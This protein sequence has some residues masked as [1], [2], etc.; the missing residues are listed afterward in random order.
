MVLTVSLIRTG[1]QQKFEELC[2][3]D[4]RL[5]QVSLLPWDIETFGFPVATYR[6]GAEELDEALFEEAMIRFA[7][8]ARRNGVL[9]CSCV[10]PAKSNFWIGHLA[11]ARF[12]FVDFGLRPILSN[13]SHA[14]LPEARFALRL[15]EPEDWEAVEDIALQ[16]FHDG[17]YHADPFFPARL[18][19]LRYR[20]WMKR[21]L[22]DENGINRVY[23]LGPPATVQGFY[24]LTVEGTNSDLRL[25]AV[26]PSF[27]GTMLGF[28]LYVSALQELKKLGVRRIITSISAANTSVM[29]V[30]SALGFR[31]S[32]PEAIYH[33]HSE[34]ML[35]GAIA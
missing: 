25:A 17:R 2:S 12:S 15:A 35:S 28:D 3:E 5:G 24:H 27:K 18:A 33:W 34:R 14:S 20:D 1:Y 4:P 6:V 10:I 22:R 7:N 19:D 29:N 32:E 26:A 9:V 11:A 13:L 30:Y 31:F 23:V 21:A 16:S 8:W